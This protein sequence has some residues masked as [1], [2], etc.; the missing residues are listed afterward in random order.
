MNVDHPPPSTY[1]ELGVILAP[2]CFIYEYE[3]RHFSFVE[4]SM[5]HREERGSGERDRGGG[6]TVA[7]QA[8]RM[9]MWFRLTGTVFIVCSTD[10][11]EHWMLLLWPSS[12]SS[13]FY[14]PF[15]HRLLFDIPH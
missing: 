15:C 8:G 14:L 4:Q 3:S 2:L 10:L 6:E 13:S 1:V 12:T 5:G 9:G 7:G 11:P